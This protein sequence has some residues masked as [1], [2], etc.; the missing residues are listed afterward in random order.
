MAFFKKLSTLI[1]GKSNE[2][3]EA[4]E[5]RNVDTMLDQHMR[6]T[7]EEL[8]ESKKA[9]AQL[10]AARKGAERDVAKFKKQLE[11]GKAAAGNLIEQGKED[12]AEKLISKLGEEVKPS[13]LSAEDRLATATA[14]VDKVK[15]KVQ[16]NER[17]LAQFRVQA[18]NVKAQN[19]INQISKSVNASVVSE[20]SDA[21]RMQSALDRYSNRVQ[22]ESDVI[23]SLEENYSESAED[24]LESLIAEGNKADTSGKSLAD[25]LGDL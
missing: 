21:A 19:K 25:R 1:A 20:D 24:S 14:N 6:E 7:E 3:I 12:A 4:V 13:L 9:V 10:D 23:D 8:R 16:Q 18:E 11:D 22:N 5:D 2:L 15:R 17:K